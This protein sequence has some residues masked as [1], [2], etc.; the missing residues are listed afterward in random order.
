VAQGEGRTAALGET[1]GPIGPRELA[2][3]AG[4]LVT[5]VAQDRLTG[6]LRMVA[7]ANL[8]AIEKTLESGLAHF[9]SRS[10]AALWRKGES[11]G[12]ELVV[13]EI[14]VDC[15]ADAV[16]Y[17]VEPAGPSC[18][19][20]E[21]TCFFRPLEPAFQRASARARYAQPELARLWSE[22]EAR[23]DADVDASYTKRLLAKGRAAIGAK[24]T[25]ES[26]ELVAAIERESDQRVV[27][28]A[29]DVLYHVLVGLLARGVSLRDVEAELARRAGVSGLV[30][31]ASRAPK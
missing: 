14:W 10:R 5:V 26:A 25:E 20:G 27:S 31:K 1:Q 7:H 21:V 12:N 30:E 4:A 24:I 6:E 16:L 8:E 9:Y 17:L 3:D 11:S 15:D 13:H 22:L 28:E 18:H 23:R 19:T 2:F 29:A